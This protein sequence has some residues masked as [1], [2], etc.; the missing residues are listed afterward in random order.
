MIDKILK[1]YL[2]KYSYLISEYKGKYPNLS[3]DIIESDFNLCFWMAMIK[4]HPNDSEF[5]E[6]LIVLLDRQIKLS[7]NENS[8]WL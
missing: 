5:F 7:N 3:S 4:Y 1:K 2:A 6:Y 8:K